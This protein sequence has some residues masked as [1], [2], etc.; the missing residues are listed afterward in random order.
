MNN[1]FGNRE[2]TQT[3]PVQ[4]MLQSMTFSTSKRQTFVDHWN[5]DFGGTVCDAQGFGI[6]RYREE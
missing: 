6:N 5:F 1:I 3:V 4:K 2:T